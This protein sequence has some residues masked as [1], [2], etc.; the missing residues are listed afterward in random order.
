MNFV[1]CIDP[2]EQSEL[3]QCSDEAYRERLQKR[4]GYRLGRFESI[5]PRFI[6][7]LL[8]IE[9]TEQVG[10]RTVLLG[11][12]ARL[13]HPVAGQGYN[14]AVR[15]ISELVTLLDS[16]TVSDP[17]TASVLSKFAAKRCD[18][19]KSIV[20]LTDVLARGFRGKSAL[21]SHLRAGALLGLDMI[22]PIKK[23][24]VAKTTGM[25]GL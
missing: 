20:R 5:G 24:F 17:G 2:D 21:P 14:L 23:R 1:D 10:T 16:N 8:R 15:D 9:A 7:P 6:S 4:F 13:L 18:D 3:E 12:A 25:Q 19:Q 11:N 22:S